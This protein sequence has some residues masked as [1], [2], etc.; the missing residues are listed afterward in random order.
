MA[1]RE[2][3][4]AEVAEQLPNSKKEKKKVSQ[5]LFLLNKAPKFPMKIPWLLERALFIK[6]V[7]S[8]KVKTQSLSCCKKQKSFTWMTVL[9]SSN[10]NK[11]RLC[12]IFPGS[13]LEIQKQIN[14]IFREEMA[15]LFQSAKMKRAFQNINVCTIVKNKNSI[16]KTCCKNKN[17]G[18]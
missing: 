5:N 17:L 18:S 2:K 15:I 1:I 6:K 14:E 8:L 9:S 13:M 11:E 10:K 4:S 3:V 7:S 12:Y 16:K